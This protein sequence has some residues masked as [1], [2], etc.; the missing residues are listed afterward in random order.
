MRLGVSDNDHRVRWAVFLRVIGNVRAND[1][2]SATCRAIYTL[3]T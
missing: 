3:V 2:Y 1:I